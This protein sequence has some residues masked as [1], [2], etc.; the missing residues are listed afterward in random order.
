MDNAAN[1]D[2]MMASLSLDLLRRFDIHYDPKVHR[3]R[4]Q[5][6]VIDLAAKAFLFVT[7]NETLEHAA[8]FSAAF[9]PL[10]NLQS[11]RITQIC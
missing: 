9:S 1:N 5:G 7:D 2:T 8:H 6:H 4:C 10:G 3:L 11:I